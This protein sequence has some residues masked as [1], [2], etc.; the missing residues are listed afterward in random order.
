MLV[1]FLYLLP[2][3]YH[4]LFPLDCWLW[5]HCYSCCLGIHSNCACRG[6]RRML[7]LILYCLRLNLTLHCFY[8]LGCCCCIGFGRSTIS[9]FS[10]F[11]WCLSVHDSL[12]SLAEC[13][14]FYFFFQLVSA[15]LNV[16]DPLLYRK[17]LW[18][19]FPCHIPDWGFA[20]VR[21][22][23]VESI[24]DGMY[25]LLS[26]FGFSVFGLEFALF[27]CWKCPLILSS[28]K[29]TSFNFWISAF[30]CFLCSAKLT[31]AWFWFVLSTWYCHIAAQ[32]HVSAWALW[33]NL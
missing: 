28:Q 18:Y 30:E 2:C 20:Y 10:F 11:E 4:L 22:K 8:W 32:F 7:D 17:V 3:F 13:T 16:F 6:S 12:E 33:G 19:D 29:C 26:L 25:P 15:F 9:D 24:V 23:Q 21:C 5:L 1:V 31:A 27:H 14:Y